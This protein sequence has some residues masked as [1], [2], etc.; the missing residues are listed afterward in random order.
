METDLNPR[1]S[2]NS[3]HHNNRKPLNNDR[4][5]EARF[6]SLEDTVMLTRCELGK[7]GKTVEDIKDA[8]LGD[9]HGSK[10]FR[11]KVNDAYDISIVVMEEHKT[12]K[13]KV[14]SLTHESWK[15]R[16][17]IAGLVMVL[18]GLIVK[19]IEWGEKFFTGK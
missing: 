12:L 2:R 3:A 6:K 19:S 10:G 18:G 16:G 13:E 4:M 17:M 8:L 14:D 9:V 11:E 1:R 5:N 7:M 15:K